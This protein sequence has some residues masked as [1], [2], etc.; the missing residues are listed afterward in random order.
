MKKPNL[1][2]FFIF[3]AESAENREKSPVLLTD[4]VQVPLKK[5]KFYSVKQSVTSHPCIPAPLNL[6]TRPKHRLLVGIHEI[7][8]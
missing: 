1:S 7:L 6:K 8:F 4:R 5:G 2:Q 3:S